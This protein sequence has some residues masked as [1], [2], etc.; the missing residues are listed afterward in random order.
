ML[1]ERRIQNLNPGE[2]LDILIDLGLRDAKNQPDAPAMTILA[3]L[4]NDLIR[5]AFVSLDREFSD[6]I[7]VQSNVFNDFMSSVLMRKGLRGVVANARVFED[8][9]TK[10]QGIYIFLNK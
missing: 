4:H 9:Q 8:K 7:Q 1:P 3:I 5:W 2:K 6:D 10:E